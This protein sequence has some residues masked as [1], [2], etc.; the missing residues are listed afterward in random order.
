LI[1]FAAASLTDAFR[2]I[3]QEFE[4]S[5]PGVKIVYNFAGS[6]ALSTQLSEGAK[7]DVFASANMTEMKKIADAKLTGNDSQ[8]F[9]N[10]RLVVIV[11]A[12]NPGK[13]V[14]P[15][16]LATPGIKLVV[17]EPAV[18][19]GGY[20]V[21]M[22]EK[23]SAD[24][25]Y[26]TDFGAAVVKNVVSQENNVKAVVAKVSLGEADAGVAYVSDVT[27]DVADT[28]KAI[29]VPDEFNQIAHYP[30]AVLTGTVNAE[31]AQE[32]VEFILTKEDGQKILG[33]WNFIPVTE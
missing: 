5:H 2:E 26:G 9:A 27:P 30:I 7:A 8:I 28:V 32:Y 19:V 13:L 15:L 1:V 33:K 10:N 6:Q 16:D 20:T 31:L 21:S 3:A 18:P 22:L 12:D 29:Q 11:P 24:P 4:A 23:M 17:A 25:D 14:E